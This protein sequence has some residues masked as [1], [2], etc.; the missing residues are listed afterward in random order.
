MFTIGRVREK[1]HADACLTKPE[2]IERIHKVIDAVHDLLDG[3]LAVDASMSVLSAAFVEGGSG[4]W[5]RTG[6]WIRKLASEYPVINSAWAPIARHPSARIRFRVAAFLDDMPPP[7][8]GELFPLLLNDPSAKVRAKVAGD[9]R[10][11][12]SSNDLEIL[13][14][15]RSE[16][17]DPIV[18]DSI[19]YVLSS[20]KSAGA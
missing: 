1:E 7:I 13:A 18:V 2:D 8:R 9:C 16:E 10:V 3:V 15:R 12:S 5:E 19:D 20:Q 14:T 17:T 11:I 4:V 6:A